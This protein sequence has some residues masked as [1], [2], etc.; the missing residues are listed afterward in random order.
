MVALSGYNDKTL[1]VA[2]TL[3]PYGSLVPGA[4]VVKAGMCLLNWAVVYS[5]LQLVDAVMLHEGRPSVIVLLLALMMR[6]CGIPR[7]LIKLLLVWGV[8]LTVILL[9]V[10][11]ILLLLLELLLLILVVLIG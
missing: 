1:W 2:L 11:V 6:V 4:W 3:G 9:L 10:P 7:K 5:L 8:L